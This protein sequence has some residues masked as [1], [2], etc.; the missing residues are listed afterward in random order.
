MTQNEVA[1][2]L[3]EGSKAKEGTGHEMGMG[4]GLRLCLGYLKILGVDYEINS[5]EQKGT[6]F[7]L[8]LQKAK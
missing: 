4:M 3:K 8:Y 1:S 6:E 5:E 7:V 2:L